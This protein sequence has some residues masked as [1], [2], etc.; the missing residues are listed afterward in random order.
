[1]TTQLHL[2]VEELQLRHDIMNGFYHYYNSQHTKSQSG[3]DT[4]ILVDR[5]SEGSSPSA[6]DSYVL[7]ETDGRE[8]A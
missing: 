4:S 1:M 7:N 2:T 3:S 5:R 6:A 8:R